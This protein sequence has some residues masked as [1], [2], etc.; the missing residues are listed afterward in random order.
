MKILI[1]YNG[2][3]VGRQALL[4]ARSFAE[5]NNAF[6][7]IVTSMEG[8]SS[9]KKSD[10]FKA[11]QGLKFAKA[12]MEDSKVKCEARESVRG[13]TP[14]EDLVKFAEEN[15]VDHI[16]LGLKKTS[17]AQKAILGSTVRYVILKAPCPVTTTKFDLNRITAEDLLRGRRVLVVDDEPDI[18]ETVEELL[19]MCSLDKAAYFDVAKNLI[20][21]NQYDIVIL[22]IMGVHGFDLLELAREKDMPALMLTAHAMSPENL[23]EAIEKGANSFISKDELPNLVNHITEVIKN[24]ING[25]EGYGTWFSKV[26]SYFDKSFDKGWRDEDKSFWHSFDDTFY[27]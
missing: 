9:E 26:K 23:K 24:C 14:A 10:R 4:L 1:G 3:E 12:L 17:K 13:L 19:D 16:F 20:G 15:D 11:E 22:D 18:H 2:G 21:K 7:Y 6:V 25:G 8:G 5:T 27:R